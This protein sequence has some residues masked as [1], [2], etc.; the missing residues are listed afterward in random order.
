M[1][2]L[3]VPAKWFEGDTLQECHK[4]KLFIHGTEDEL[5]P[6]PLTKEWFEQVPA[7]KRL[8]AIE[9]ADH[10]FQGHL[11]EVQAIIAEFVRELEIM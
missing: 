5:A 6:Y 8:I 2:G 11:E 7:P 3:G 1:I 4:P 9:E 10:F